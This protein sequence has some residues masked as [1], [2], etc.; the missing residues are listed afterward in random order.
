MALAT[1]CPACETVFRI[2]TS[3]AAA[4]SG[5]VRCGECLHAFNSLDALVRVEDLELVE[6]LHDA[7]LDEVDAEVGSLSSHPP[8]NLP[9][10]FTG[11]EEDDDDLLELP[12]EFDLEVDA[13][14][15]GPMDVEDAETVLSNL[16]H[17]T[18][19]GAHGTD[20]APIRE[21]W[22]P[23]EGELVI[24]P[25]MPVAEEPIRSLADDQAGADWSE[26]AERDR[27]GFM[28]DAAPEKLRRSRVERV[29]LAVLSLL[30]LLV[31]AGQAAY[32]WRDEIAARVPELRPA[33]L[34]GC[35]VLRCRVDL[36]AH[37]DAVTI[38]STA[39]QLAS[40][41]GST[42]T[43]TALLRNRDPIALRYP[44]L[45]LTLT[46]TRDEPILRR[47]LR[48]EDYLPADRIAGGFAP[49]SELPVRVTFELADLRFVG[50][51]VDRFYP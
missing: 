41:N 38:E 18:D 7:P 30:A 15:L 11:E 46:D 16:T 22:Q 17:D 36:P 10:E 13:P 21:W 35:A 6:P 51:R 45:A 20:G 31:L 19:P 2:S 12:S 37:V 3:Q 33:L 23:A 50:Y 34:A 8:P 5:M 4:K 27:P 24:P 28:R 29:V 25:P 40:P 26:D 42:Y 48:P 44:N 39:V 47:V 49:D 9:P 1:R 43:L 14:T 32:A